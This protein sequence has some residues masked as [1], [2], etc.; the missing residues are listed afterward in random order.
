MGLSLGCYLL[1]KTL[2]FDL[3]HPLFSFR[4]MSGAETTISGNTLFLL[5]STLLMFFEILKAA[6]AT[7]KYIIANHVLS[8]LVFLAFIVLYITQ[9][10]CG[11][12]TFLLV[13]ALSFVDVLAGW[14]VSH[15]T[16]LR[17]MNIG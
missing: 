3:S 13:T 7:H 1:V 14:I 16:A 11:N 4:L 8:T 10:K 2:G 5:M 17:D 9:P 15:R 6:Q 12:S